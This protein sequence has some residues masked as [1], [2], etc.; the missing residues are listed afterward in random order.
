MGLTLIGRDGDRKGWKERWIRTLLT[1][2]T[3][4]GRDAGSEPERDSDQRPQG[5]HM[6]DHE[7]K[8]SFKAQQYKVSIRYHF[9]RLS[10][11]E[12]I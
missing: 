1:K 8:S 11:K 2:G 7:S 3:V 6:R 10:D 9:H 12:N 4:I 5:D